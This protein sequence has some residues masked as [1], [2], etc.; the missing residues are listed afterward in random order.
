MMIS[1]PRR[2]RFL[3]LTAPQSPLHEENLDQLVNWQS[4]W[5]GIWQGWVK[6]GRG[7]ACLRHSVIS[8]CT[9]S[10]RRH[11]IAASK[12]NHKEMNQLNLYWRCNNKLS[13]IININQVNQALLQ[14]LGEEIRAA[15]SHV[16]QLWSLY[17][18]L[19]VCKFFG[20]VKCLWICMQY[21]KSAGFSA[22]IDVSLHQALTQV[23]SAICCD[24]IIISYSNSEEGEA[25]FTWKWLAVFALIIIIMLN[26]PKGAFK[27]N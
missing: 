10:C 8:A 12:K 15:F 5:H 19:H 1:I 21:M 6:V 16:G 18:P 9:P 11:V 17:G 25:C 3:V 26:V 20:A 22:K 27:W 4:S 2:A 13:V 24:F 7:P 14:A 23:T